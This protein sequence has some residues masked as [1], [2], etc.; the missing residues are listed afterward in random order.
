MTHDRE[1]PLVKLALALTA[2]LL[3]CVGGAVLTMGIWERS[4]PA[5]AMGV[6]CVF[7]ALIVRPT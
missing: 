2:T 3:V 7:G 4:V 5:A 1:Q 6:A